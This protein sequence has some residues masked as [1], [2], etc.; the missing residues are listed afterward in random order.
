MVAKQLP[1]TLAEPGS[2]WP[3]GSIASVSRKEKHLEVLWMAPNGSIQSRSWSGDIGEWT[4]VEVAPPGSAHRDSSITAVATE[5]NHTF[6]L[7]VHRR[8]L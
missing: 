6:A 4:A 2:A 3:T 5:E 1:L 7:W 8:A